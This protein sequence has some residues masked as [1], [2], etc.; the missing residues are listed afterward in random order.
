MSLAKRIVEEF[1]RTRIGG[2]QDTLACLSLVGAGLCASTPLAAAV[3][4]LVPGLAALLGAM[5]FGARFTA[6]LAGQAI[7][8]SNVEQESDETP[9]QINRSQWNGF[10]IGYS[11]DTGQPIYLD[12]ENAMRHILVVGM[13]GVGKT[14]LGLSLM[15]QQIMRGGGVLFIDGKI[16]SKEISNVWYFAHMAGRGNDLRIINPGNP[17]LSHRY[18]PIMEGDADEV[19]SRVLSI[20]PSTENNPGADHYRQEANTGLSIIVGA[21][22]RAGLAYTMIDVSILLMSAAAMQELERMLAHSREGRDSD[23]L[24]N[25]RLFLDKFRAPDPRTGVMVMNISKLKDTFGGIG[26][27]LFQFGTGNF[28]QVMNTYNPDVRI[29]DAI[30]QRLIVY[31]ALPTMGKTEVARNFGKLLIGDYRTAISWIQ[32]LPESERPNPPHLTWMDETGS[33]ATQ[34]LS[35]PFEQGR[36]ARQI[37]AASMQTEAN[38]AAVSDEFSEMVRGNTWTRIY[39]KIGNQETAEAAAEAIGQEVGIL[40][41]L[42]DSESSSNNLSTLRHTPEGSSGLSAGISYGEREQEQYRVTADE[43]KELDKGEVIMTYGSKQRYSLRIPMLSVS[44]EAKARFGPVRLK[45]I[46]PTSSKPGADF[47]VN[48][49]R[50]L[51]ANAA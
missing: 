19:A 8:P 48:P 34:A 31:V 43:L 26:G 27:R 16:D 32:A 7:L 29:Y 9:H 5:H 15:Y 40:R 28:G 38:L 47:A 12:D 45:R 18:N 11:T 14:V 51:Q 41:S 10:L 23:E 30:R 37:L 21:L 33:F 35:V 6:P 3:S 20:I 36:S 24:K 13:T 44:P 50:F 42:S 17:R 39:F 49:D 2:T 4:P 1:F 46:P 22:Q 25:Y